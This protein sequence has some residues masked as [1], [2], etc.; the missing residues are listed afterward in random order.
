M[1]WQPQLGD[2]FYV[3]QE[4]LRSPQGHYTGDMRESQHGKYSQEAKIYGSF[5]AT[6]EKEKRQAPVEFSGTRRALD[7]VGVYTDLDIVG[8]LFVP[9]LY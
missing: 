1:V 6:V 9:K 5:I 8:C 3:W 7:G 2:D 4:S